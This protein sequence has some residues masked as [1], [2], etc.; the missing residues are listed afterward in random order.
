MVLHNKA[1][2]GNDVET[3]VTEWEKN[4]II[5]LFKKYDTDSSGA[6]SI[7]E[8]TKFVNDLR[9]DKCVM[10]KVPNLGDE[11]VEKIFEDF[12]KTEDGK[13]ELEEFR[14]KMNNLPWRFREK[15]EDL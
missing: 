7:E 13:I 12:D 10:G 11:D 9:S 6:L 1:K 8:M 3:K 2:F 4:T 14:T 15:G 5:E